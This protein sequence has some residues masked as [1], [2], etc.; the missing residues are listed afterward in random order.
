MAIFLSR[1]YLESFLLWIS[2]LSFISCVFLSYDT[3][4][5]YI[6]TNKDLTQ[7]FH[8]RYSR[9]HRHHTG[10]LLQIPNYNDQYFNYLTIHIDHLVHTLISLPLSSCYVGMKLIISTYTSTI[11]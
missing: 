5:Q 9:E 11:V 3:T 4:P 7:S 8:Y 10:T 6:L 1:S 2:S